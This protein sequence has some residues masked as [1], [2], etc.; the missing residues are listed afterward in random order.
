MIIFLPWCVI[1][2]VAYI[3]N[4]KY[5]TLVSSLGA[6]WTKYMESS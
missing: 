6:S 4:E 2:I 1:E 3:M 5:V